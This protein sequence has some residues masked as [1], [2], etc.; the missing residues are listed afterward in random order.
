MLGTSLGNYRVVQQLSEGGMGVVYIGHHEALG[1]RVVVKVLQPELS[2]DADMVQR[3]FN[4]ARAATAIRSPGIVQVFDFGFTPDRRAYFVMELLEG[5]SLAARLKHRFHDP[6]ECCRL[7]RQVANVLHAAHAAGITHRDLKPPNLFLVPDPEVAGGERVKVLDFGI[8]KL[9]GEAR[10]AGV[11]TRTGLIM[12]TPYYMSPEQCRS[13]S[14]ADARSDIYSLGCILFQIA[15]GRPPFVFAGVGD[16][17]AAHLH[18]PPPAPHQLAPGIPPGL[19]AL[20]SSMLA[21]FPDARP[22]TM[23]AVGQALDDLLRTLDPASAGPSRRPSTQPSTQLPGAASSASPPHAPAHAAA[24][25]HAAALAHAPP[26]LPASAYPAGLA[27]AHPPPPPIAPPAAPAGADLAP[28]AV[29]Q[30]PLLAV[31]QPPP[32][33]SAHPL[34][35][36]IAQPIRLPRPAIPDF[37]SIATTLRQLSGSFTIRRERVRRWTFLFGALVIAGA[38]TA[39]AIVLGNAPAGPQERTVPYSKIVGS[40]AAAHAAAEP[41]T[42]ASGAATAP[43]ASDRPAPPDAAS[44]QAT[45][46]TQATG[47]PATGTPATG[48]P[49]TGTPATGTPAT[50]TP[51]TGHAR[52]PRIPGAPSTSAAGAP[53]MATT[54]EAVAA[55]CQRDLHDRRWPDLA[56]CADKLKPLDPRLAA[57][58]AMRAAK[59]LD[60]APHVAAAQAALHDGELKRARAEIR[61]GL[62]GLRRVRRPQAC[63]RCRRGPEDRRARRTAPAGGRERRHLFGLQP[64]PHEVPRLGPA[65]RRPGSRPSDSV[66]GRDAEVRCGRAGGAR[67]CPGQ[68]EPVRRRARR[69]RRGLRVQASADA[70]AER[71]RRRM[72]HA[73]QGRSALV[74]EAALVGPARPVDQRVRD[75][76]HHRVDVEH[77]LTVVA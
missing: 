28:L 2:N 22:Q 57:E 34:G 62:A 24:S 46:A 64:A 59:Q 18:E 19:S 36:P 66:Q 20:I 1:R 35:I 58:L 41:A 9:A 17:V 74:L 39:I 68:Q 61:P 32:L 77:S 43:D 7:G 31:A 56:Q 16:I 4:E 49:A 53:S 44:P 23:A 73:L 33:N 47:T 11:Q 8:A 37:S 3:F 50:G 27:M 21:K 45:E 75:A 14:A 26:G 5:E 54:A 70:A 51:A 71:L 42:A 30:A 72:Q 29:A 48:T 40:A 6:A 10:S 69:L 52:P 38:I 67:P 65:A 12:G 60:S 55:E 13:A 15:C 25:A 76:R 63:L